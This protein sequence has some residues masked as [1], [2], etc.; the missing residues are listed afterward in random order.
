MCEQTDTLKL[1]ILSCF[2]GKR[3]HASSPQWTSSS[4]VLQKSKICCLPNHNAIMTG[5]VHV[6]A[7]HVQSNLVRREQVKRDFALSGTQSYAS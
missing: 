7:N 5:M 1:E 3:F 6:V 2:S 4:T